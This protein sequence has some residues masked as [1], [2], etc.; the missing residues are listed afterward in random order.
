MKIIHAVSFVVQR[1]YRAAGIIFVLYLIGI[2]LL[3][4]GPIINIAFFKAAID[5]ITNNHTFLGMTLLG[6]VVMR[7]GFE[8]LQNTL[9]KANEYLWNM[10]EVKQALYN[11][12]AFVDKLATL[13]LACIENP[14]VYDKIWRSFN[15]LAW[16]L[17]YYLDASTK[18]LGKTIELSLS[19]GI[20]L[21]ASPLSALFIVIANIVPILIRGK[22]GDLSF[23]IYKAD[24]ELR[25]KYE[26]TSSLVT[27]REV[28]VELKQYQGFQFA[29]KKLVEIYDSFGNKQK[30]LYKKSWI[31]F[32]YVDLL[33]IAAIFFFLITLALQL[34]KH[35]ITTGTFVFLF[36]NIFV[37]NSALAQLGNYLGAVI[38]ESSSMQDALDY[39]QLQPKIQFPLLSQSDEKK[40]LDKL[41]HPTIEIKNLSYQYP[42]A[43]QKALSHINLTIPYGQNIA[44]IGVN[45]AGKS[46]LVKLL[47]RVYDPT[48]GEIFMNGINL[49]EIPEKIIFKTY[50]TLFQSFG[51]FYLTIRENLELAAGKKLSDDEYIEALK[52]SHSWAF[53][54]EFPETLD[55]QLGP[56]YT[57]GIDLSGGQWQQLAIG[58]TLIRKTPVLI[59]DEP[60]SAVDAQAEMEIFDR[61]QKETKDSTVIFISHRFSTIKDAE[62]IIV[63]DNG[64]II[65]DGNHKEL[66][67]QEGKYANLYTLQAKR[68]MRV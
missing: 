55:Q 14:E 49:K 48:E 40:L 3:A 32:S 2:I 11:V 41:Q 24:S 12:T 20:F 33:P 7:F 66:M 39:Y 15:R 50:S 4:F 10:I 9:S 18:L 21:F 19:I 53:I 25:R 56:T 36:T 16:Q 31:V 42:N 47:L 8:V 57:N 29:K 46:T 52:K 13:D 59:L 60:T 61:L 30:Q 35:Q 26:Y 38:S 6:I 51:K 54:K 45:G 68:Y 62:R 28:I 58:K 64:G 65:E 17:R 23:N 67:Q 22:L 1:A 43:P 27:N 37:F 44:L 34:E 5:S 63:L